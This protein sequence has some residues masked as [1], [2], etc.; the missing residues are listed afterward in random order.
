MPHRWSTP[1]MRGM[2]ASRILVGYDGSPHSGDA[3]ALARV[4]AEATG[5]EIVLG[6][7]VPWEPLSLT[8]VPLPEL[9]Q[10][11]EAQER[12]AVEELAQLARREGVAPE[13][14]PG[15]SPAE[16]LHDLAG[17]LDPELVVVGSSHRGT[18]GQVFAGN[19]ALRLLNGLDR[20]LAVA[21]A[22]Y[23]NR[24]HRLGT[25]GVGFDGSPESRVALETAGRLARTA[26]ADVEVI[27]VA[28][29]V[30][31]LT[32][33]PWAFGWEAGALRED[34]DERMRGR[35]E[36]A[37]GSLPQGVRHSEQVHTGAA[38]DV[39]LGA[40]D[41]L[42]LLVVGS[43]GYGPARRVLLGS[44]SGR[45][46]REACCPVLVTPRAAAIQRE[47][48]PAAVEPVPA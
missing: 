48:A 18:I 39:L 27:G 8:A 4:L 20:P 16:G 30:A 28:V 3:F 21:P 13:V 37:A 35:V 40:T 6:R 17:E 15:G 7:V 23:A 11:F 1:I 24:Q 31:A 44:V 42:D 5:A 29:P 10:R 26:D 34:L 12:Q 38:A 41:Y 19:V 9:R 47:A 25:I 14:A 33:H 43:R 36:S 22:G 32:P 2:G 46:V 45:L